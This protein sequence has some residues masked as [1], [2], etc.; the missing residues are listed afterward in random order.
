ML[1][2]VGPVLV[3]RWWADD[4]A[5]VDAMRAATVAKLGAAALDG[6][7]AIYAPV[8]ADALTVAMD[9][10]GALA[11]IGPHGHPAYTI[12][13]AAGPA[14]LRGEGATRILDGPAVWR[15][16]RLSALAALGEVWAAAE[17]AA[18]VPLGLGAFRA[19]PGA[20]ARFGERV[21]LVRDYR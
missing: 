7:D 14:R 16:S 19:P 2:D 15:A 13:L 17:V 11:G 9:L 6:P 21:F 5:W 18:P 10:V 4:P 20:E 1:I 8:G 3:A 12:G